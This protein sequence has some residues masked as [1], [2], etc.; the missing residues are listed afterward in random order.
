MRN[1]AHKYGAALEV[2]HLAFWTLRVCNS[3][4]GAESM[5][6]FISKRISSM[7]QIRDRY[8]VAPRL[9]MS[10]PGVTK[11]SVMIDGWKTVRLQASF[12]CK[13]S[14]KLHNLVEYVHCAKCIAR[15]LM[16]TETSSRCTAQL[17]PAYVNSP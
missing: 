2:R 10:A 13:L 3:G 6:A 7:I 11:K 1:E 4:A 15:L 5:Y 8:G 17:A 14:S 9:V 12:I 16:H